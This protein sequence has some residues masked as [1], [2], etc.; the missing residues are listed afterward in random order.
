MQLWKIAEILGVNRTSVD[1]ACKKLGLKKN[2]TGPKS[3]E[4]HTNW[5]GGKKMVGRYWYIYTSTHPNRTTQ[6]YIAEHRLVAE[7]KLGRFLTRT[8]VVH[9]LDG[10]PIN[11]HP[12]NLVV[13]QSNAAHLAQHFSGNEEHGEAIAEGMAK[14]QKWAS[15]LERLKLYGRPELRT[16]NRQ[17]KRS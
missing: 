5:K 8:E 4:R 13:F 15:N 7:Q 1:R 9:H 12:D 16:K 3:A 17:N 6:N 14:S 11:N 10:N 2:R